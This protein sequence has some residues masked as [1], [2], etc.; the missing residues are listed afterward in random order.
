MFSEHDVIEVQAASAGKYLNSKFLK[1]L[2]QMATKVRVLG[3]GSRLVDDYNDKTKKKKEVYLEVVSTIGSFE[4]AKD[5]A[6]N[7]T[8]L[9]ILLDGLGKAPGGWVGREFGVYFDPRVKVGDE[10][11]GGIRV[12]VF[13]ADPFAKIEASTSAPTPPPAAAPVADDIPF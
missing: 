3:G 6:L 13:E 12:K 8:N 7:R 10:V 2:P 5:L 4:G 11:K 9:D 1:T